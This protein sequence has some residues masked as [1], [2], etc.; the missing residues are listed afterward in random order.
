M[1]WTVFTMKT[2]NEISEY[3]KKKLLKLLWIFFFIWK[4]ILNAH[5]VS[6]QSQLLL[7]IWMGYKVIDVFN[8][9]KWT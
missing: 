5:K 2:I 4:W 1:I 6:I 8:E 7:T 3:T 9:K